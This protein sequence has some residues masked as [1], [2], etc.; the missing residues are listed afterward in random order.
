MLDGRRAISHRLLPAPREF[1]PAPGA[2]L[3]GSDTQRHVGGDDPRLHRAVDRWLAGFPR[4]DGRSGRLDIAIDRGAVR[5]AH[6]YR[7]TVTPNRVE[8]LGGSPAGCFQGLQTVAQLSDREKATLPCCTIVD[9]PDF[10][11]RG[12]LHD[13]TRGRVPMLATL[14]GLVDRLAA[15]K[16]NQLQLYLEHAFV[17]SF[18]T[19]ICSPE[20]GLTPDE[21]HELSDYCHERFIDLVPALATFGH[22]GRILSMPNYRHLAEVEATTTWGEMTW[23]RRARGFTLDCVNAESHRLVERMWSE[24]LDA[25]PSPVVNICGDEPWDLGQG[26]NRERFATSGKGVAYIEQIRRTYDICAARGRR[27]QAWSDV[28]R[29]YPDLLDRLPHDLTV[30]HWGYDDKADYD[31][32]GVFTQVGFETYVCP[33]TSG[34]KRIVSA[35]GLAERNIATFAEAGRRFGA[36]GLVNT[37]WGDHGHFHPLSCSMHGIATGAALAWRA[38]HPMGKDLDAAGASFDHRF[39]RVVWGVNDATGVALLRNA[40]AAG[41]TCET[42]RLMWLPLEAVR[43]D[44]TLPTIDAATAMRE[45]A[46]DFLAWLDRQ[47]RA[48]FNDPLDHDE[49]AVA[50]RFVELFA[51]KALFARRTHP[52]DRQAWAEALAHASNRYAT[53]W[54][55]RNK[56]SGLADILAALSVQGREGEQK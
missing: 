46:V 34:W 52:R 29:N 7:F 45:D 24:V 11:T 28:V 41:D 42:W 38:D 35:M 20:E 9:W 8:L 40:A 6:G 54:R 22:M 23:P 55:A 36:K 26:K 37:D 31:G 53:N 51:E 33:G 12:L 14:K 3:V 10:E 15:L 56:S 44:A 17:F 4:N 18:D 21:V 5:H 39:A 2:F 50:A 13:V 25:F 1:T 32:T 48:A 43:D 19:D 16:I 49:L 30:L 47:N 27:V